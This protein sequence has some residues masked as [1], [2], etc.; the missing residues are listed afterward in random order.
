[1]A[2][3]VRAVTV[4]RVEPRGRRVAHDRA[5]TEEPMEIRLNGVPFAVV[6]RTP[7]N[8]AELAAGFLFAER[9]IGGIEEIGTIEH[10]ERRDRAGENVIDVRLIGAARRRLPRLMSE[11]RQ[12]VAHSGCGVCG[13]RTIESLRVRAPRINARWTIDSQL[14]G[15]LPARLRKA[16]SAFDQ[17]GGIHAA[18]IFAPDGE[19]DA[20]AEDVGRHNAVDKV[21]GR[22][23]MLER[24]PLKRAVL[25]V[26]GRASFEIVQKAYLSGVPI[27][28]AVSAPS[29]LAIDLAED[30]GITLVGFVRDDRF[31]IYCH[32]RRVKA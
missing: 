3:G 4:L 12:V 28:A 9:V 30:A 11:R 31:N 19:L 7:G 5:A 22:M 14:L 16:Q 2:D 18:G 20:M 13:R 27:I 10:C 21:I 24:L 17:T 26:S 23:M 29:T 15:G 6:M 25:T 1:M 8:D 32:E